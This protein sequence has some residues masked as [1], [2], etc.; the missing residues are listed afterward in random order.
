MNCINKSLALILILTIT[1]S[2]LS[3]IFEAIPLGRALSGTNE[4]G[5]INSDITWTKAGSPYI[6]TGPLAVNQGVILTIEA[7]TTI[8][9]N[10]HYIQVNG[11]LIAKGSNTD[12][13]RMGGNGQIIFTSLSNGWNEQT[14]SGII[15]EDSIINGS[16]VSSDVTIKILNSTIN[17]PLSV[18]GSSLI[19]NSNVGQVSGNAELISGSTTGTLNIDAFISN[20]N[21]YGDVNAPFSTII[22]NKIFGN[23][24]GSTITSNNIS[25]DVTVNSGTVTNNTIQGGTAFYD[26][27]G[28]VVRDG[29]AVY[30]TGSSIIS[31]NNLTSEAGQSL[32]TGILAENDSHLLNNIISGFQEGIN[33]GIY[34][35]T[36][37]IENNLIFNNVYGI[38]INKVIMTI[39]NN[40]IFNNTYGI[41]DQWN[42]SNPTVVYNNIENNTQ[43][44]SLTGP[45]NVTAMH[46]WW[47]TTDQQAINQTIYDFKND[48]NLGIVNFVPFLTAPN[49]QAPSVNTPLTT[50]NPSASPSTSQTPS[51]SPIG[52]GFPSWTIPMIIGIIVVVVAG[53]LVYHRSKKDKH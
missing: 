49:L 12:P 6:L 3:L 24:I 50:P 17:Q 16:S 19:L 10:A 36:S 32:T 1:I 35:G 28:R 41:I 48:F 46:N 5:I 42:P 15:I 30:T 14:G 31:N 33:G 13:V 51:P 39:T 34:D 22:N 53:L 45:S 27:Y 43:N 9:I 40:T 23:V 20:N 37:I 11:T 2:C 47:G 29:F 4:S 18:S 44:L 8:N 25:G 7:G 38:A 21:I 26:A 52:A